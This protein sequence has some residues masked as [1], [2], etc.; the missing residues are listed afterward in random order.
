MSKLKQ[1]WNSFLLNLA[2]YSIFLQLRRCDELCHS[3]GKNKQSYP[4]LFKQT[5]WKI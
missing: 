1:I 2:G 3:Y 5:F 4:D